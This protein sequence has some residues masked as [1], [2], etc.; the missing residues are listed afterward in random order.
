M[1]RYPNESCMKICFIFWM[2][3]SCLFASTAAYFAYLNQ[4]DQPVQEVSD[5]VFGWL[6]TWL[7][8]TS[9]SC[10]FC[11]ILGPTIITMAFLIEIRVV[12]CLIGTLLLIL[13][14]VP[15]FVLY[16]YVHFQL[17]PMVVTPE[18]V[19]NVTYATQ[20]SNN[21]LLSIEEGMYRALDKYV[22]HS[23][24]SGE[25]GDDWDWVQRNMVCCGVHGPDDWQRQWIQL[26]ESLTETTKAYDEY[27]PAMAVSCCAHGY[28]VREMMARELCYETRSQGCFAKVVDEIENVVIRMKVRSLI[29]LSLMACWAVVS[30]SLSFFWLC[31]TIT[32]EMPTSR[33]KRR[34]REAWEP[35]TTPPMGH[36]SL[37]EKKSFPKSTPNGK[38]TMKV[39]KVN[40]EDGAEWAAA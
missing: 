7:S 14:C 10:L 39:S 22:T 1:A 11:G 5:Y 17:R 23:S 16:S 38:P 9:W 35:E 2:I 28:R 37:L 36:T 32:A 27:A 20:L 40:V 12:A 13:F 24:K 26:Q 29:G 31:V 25:A 18:P 34:S 8:A 15:S 3:I 30:C 6:N 4:I 19:G 33:K 21:T